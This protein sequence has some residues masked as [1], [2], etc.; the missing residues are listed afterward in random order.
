M[1]CSIGRHQT[2]SGHPAVAKAHGAS[3]D[4]Y[5]PVISNLDWRPACDGAIIE[6]ISDRGKILGIHASAFHSAVIAEW[7]I[8]YADGVPVSAEYR[9]LTRGRIQEGDRAGE[10]SGENTVK[11][12]ST[13]TWNGAHFPIKDES[14]R[15]ELADILQRSKQEAEQAGS[16]QPATRP[17]VEPAGGDK[18][19]PEAEGR[20]R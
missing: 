2:T 20:S 19:Q 9:E 12:I 14:R 17:V 11:E 15:K 7:S 8:H 16:G 3:L 5:E 1:S 10:Y 6:V 13:W 18:P 4:A